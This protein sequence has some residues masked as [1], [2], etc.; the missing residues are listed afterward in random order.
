MSSN[1][2]KLTLAVF[3]GGFLGTILRF[4]INQFTAGTM[5]PAG[6]VVEN[7]TGSFLLGLVT[8]WIIIRHV[9]PVLK[10]GIGA[11]FCGGYT[12]MSTFMGDV[13]LLSVTSESA[14]L[15]IAT[16]VLI[17]LSGGMAAAWF[18]IHLGQKAAGGEGK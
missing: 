4:L 13:G 18:G 12:T 11:G 17:S 1:T 3:A 8:G 2:L 7:I 10:E 15:M 16:Y 5:F 6:T 9:S 14:V